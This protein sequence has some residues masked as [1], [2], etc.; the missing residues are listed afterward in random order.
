MKG[1]FLEIKFEGGLGNQ[2]FQYA[3][4][5]NLCI[6][7]NIPYLLLNT[8]SYID[9]PLNRKFSLVNFYL[10]GTVVKSSFLKN[11]FKPQ[12]KLNNAAKFLGLWKLIEEKDFTLHNIN[13]QTGILISLKGYWQSEYYFKDIRKLLQQELLPKE[14]P[15]LPGWTNLKNTVA[16]HVRRTD[17]L[18]EP[19]YG[20]VGI[21]YYHKAIETINTKISDPLF[22]FFSDD[23]GWCKENFTADN[24]FFF[25]E[26]LW[27]DDYLQLYLMS[28]CSHQIIANS[29]FSWWS[30]WLNNNKDKII[31]RPLYPFKVKS[32]LYESHYPSEWIAIDNNER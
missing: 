16:I 14:T 5:R 32:L 13:G 15:A 7:N 23:I 18:Q 27:Q 1:L 6:Q 3:A 21:E 24:I 9:Q 20:F 11:I 10:K 26:Q 4:A 19:R 2:I 29:S 28:K 17:Y 30:A 8:D 12:T 22:I 31:V 25:E